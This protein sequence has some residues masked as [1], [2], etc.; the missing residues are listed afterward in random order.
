MGLVRIVAVLKFA[1]LPQYLTP[2]CIHVHRPS[3]LCLCKY[4]Y[5][6]R[7]SFQ[8]KSVIELGAGVGSSAGTLYASCSPTQTLTHS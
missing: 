5:S 6:V 1:R 7:D 2:A 8:G 3:A 4:I